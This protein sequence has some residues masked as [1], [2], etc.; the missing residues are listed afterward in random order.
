MD[1]RVSED[2]EFLKQIPNVS[3]VYRFYASSDKNDELLYVGKAIN[4]FNRVKSYFGKTTSQ[5]PRISLMIA[6]IVRIEITVTD[7][8][9]SALILE[10]NL[11]KSLKPKYNIIFRDDKSYPLIRISNHTFPKIDVYRG[12]TNQKA[13]QYFGPYPNSYAVTNA[14]NIIQKLF[15]LRTCTDSVFANR[16]R[17]CM[18]HQIKLCTAPCVGYV[19]NEEYKSQVN[20]AICF[21]K[22]SYA[23]ITNDLTK[24][25]NDKAKQMEFEAAA[26]IRDKITLLNNISLDQVINN[27]NQP[28]TA[29]V[30]VAKSYLNQVFIYLISLQNGIYSGDKHFIINDPDSN[31]RVV[32]EVFIQNYY[33]EHQHTRLVYLQIDEKTPANLDQEFLQMF[34]AATKIRVISL[35]TIVLKKIFKMAE[36]NLQRII[37]NNIA[38]NNSVSEF[39]TAAAKLASL[40]GIDTIDRI[41]CVDISHHQGTNATASC[42]V[43]QDG[44][45]NNSL[46]RRY[47]LP[48]SVGGDDLAGMKIMLERRLKSVDLPV[49]QVILI[50]GGITQYEML[51]NLIRTSALCDKIRAVSIFKGEKRNPQYDRVIINDQLIL[52]Y[53]D[54]PGLFRLL[55]GLRDEAH[56]FAITGHRKAQIK[57]MTISKLENIPNVGATKR[58]SLLTHFGGLKGVMQASVEQLQKVSGIGPNLALQIFTY[59]HNE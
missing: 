9:A 58:K 5:S 29:D 40:L 46:Y 50:D 56:R 6:Q 28:V 10:N 3:G 34:Y 16:S 43:Y 54:D 59:F 51:K 18:L 45:I 14:I 2:K 44:K 4:L 37:N 33:L 38:N 48:D 20:L 13:N 53:R 12:K 17:P 1:I 21:L 22:G 23:Q 35:R 52:G 36:I 25:M 55:Q 30:I 42:V 47:N 32:L 11:I 41:E 7:N 49:P 24:Q 8:E 57:T 31:I 15:K 26:A 39:K 27:H 19:D